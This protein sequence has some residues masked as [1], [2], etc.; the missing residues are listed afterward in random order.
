M[1]RTLFVLILAFTL[2]LLGVWGAYL[3][4][5][6]SQGFI[7]PAVTSGS[8][9]GITYVAV[10]SP[11]WMVINASFNGR[12]TVIVLD[13]LSNETL[14]ASNVSGHLN[15]PI[16]LPREGSYAIYTPNGSLTISGHYNG[17]HPTSKVQ[18]VLYASIAVLSFALALWRWWR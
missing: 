4:V 2:S 15:V 7:G 11:G 14:F 5:E 8:K 12:G 18:K 1:R 10:H 13:Q 16:V 17:I 9:G 3:T 6:G